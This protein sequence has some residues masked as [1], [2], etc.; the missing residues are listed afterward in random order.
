MPPRLH[1]AFRNTV[2]AWQRCTTFEQACRLTARM[3]YGELLWGP[4]H[5][6]PSDDASIAQV[7][8]QGS[9][10]DSESAPIASVLGRINEAGM[11]T[12]VSQ[13]AL[14]MEGINPW[15]RDKRAIW[16][17]RAFVS[18]LVLRDRARPLVKAMKAIG[19]SAHAGKHHPGPS[20]TWVGRKP[21]TW[22]HGPSLIE[23]LKNDFHGPISEAFLL[24]LAVRCETVTFVDSRLQENLLFDDLLEEL[25]AL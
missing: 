13:P 14:V 8:R 6:F 3:A 4:G 15:K 23:S 7:L 22:A 17:Q 11:L 10:L 25:R 2:E 24:G 12:T 5:V 19:Y 20:V 18:G 16:T 1:P 9:N 21:Y